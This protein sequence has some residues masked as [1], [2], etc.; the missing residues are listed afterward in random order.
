MLITLDSNFDTDYVIY[1][2]VSAKTLNSV[3][4][5]TPKQEHARVQFLVFQSIK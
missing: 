4:H 1:Q 2:K 5:A 3:V